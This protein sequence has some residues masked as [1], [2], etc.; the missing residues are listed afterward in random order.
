M[1][2]QGGSI[3]ERMALFEQKLSPQ[4]KV[5]PSSSDIEKP[6]GLQQPIGKL[7]E[8]RSA[9]LA[10]RSIGEAPLIEPHKVK[11]LSSATSQPLPISPNALCPPSK[12]FNSTRIVN[13]DG[14]AHPRRETLNRELCK[15]AFPR[16]AAQQTANPVPCMRRWVEYSKKTKMK[17]HALRRLSRRKR[18]KRSQ[19]MSAASQVQ[20]RGDA[21][22]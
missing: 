8:A 22:H 18:W 5:S 1:A 4:P 7:S 21:S 6:V 2:R 10:S 11:A 17:S 13:E 20:E 16:N 9:L 19:P 15:A 12:V 3:K 14:R